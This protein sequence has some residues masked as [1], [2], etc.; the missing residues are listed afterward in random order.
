MQIDFFGANCIRIKTKKRTVVFDDNLA[1]V[2]QKSITTLEDVAVS[3]NEQLLGL[4][5]KQEIAF[6]LPGDYE[7][8]DIMLAGIAVRSHMDEEGKMSATVFRGIAEDMR[9][10]VLGHIYPELTNNQ[11]EEIG[12]VDILFIPVGGAGYTLDGIGAAKLVKQLEPKLVIPTHYAQK[13]ITYEVPQN[14]YDEFVKT[15]AVEPQVQD[16]KSLKLK[17]SDLTETMQVF[18]LQ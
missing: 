6:T 15:L 16:G 14:N 18:I 13:G 4:P 2:G 3:T 8:G 11:L 1:K 10:V 17:K 5:P 9:F 12:V 7:V